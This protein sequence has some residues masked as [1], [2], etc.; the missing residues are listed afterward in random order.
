MVLRDRPISFLLSNPQL[1]ANCSQNLNLATE[2][3]VVILHA[4]QLSCKPRYL[5]GLGNEIGDRGE[6]FRQVGL[7]LVYLCP[8]RCDLGFQ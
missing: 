7:S 3:C 8:Q 2:G 1:V 4:F 5:I 6:G